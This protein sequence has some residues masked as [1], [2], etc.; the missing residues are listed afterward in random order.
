MSYH[1][2]LWNWKLRDAHIVAKRFWQLPR[3]AGIV[4]NGL[5]QHTSGKE[6]KRQVDISLEDL[7]A[8][9]LQMSQDH[10]MSP[11]HYHQEIKNDG[12]F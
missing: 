1:I 4:E 6:G 12:R 5:T 9:R 10:Q 11:P 8:F 2:L 7:T 3:S